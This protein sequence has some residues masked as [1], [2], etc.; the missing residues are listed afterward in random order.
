MQ[1]GQAGRLPK[2]VFLFSEARACR[3]LQCYFSAPD[4][5]GLSLD[6]NSLPATKQPQE[7]Q[8]KVL[9]EKESGSGWETA[10]LPK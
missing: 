2:S 6:P 4:L 5:M 9:W 7:G 1:Q 10:G 8:E 3:F